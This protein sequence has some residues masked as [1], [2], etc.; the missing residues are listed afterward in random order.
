[1]AGN[2]VPLASKM[3]SQDGDEALERAIDGAMMMT[4]RSTPDSL[5]YSRPKFLGSWKSSWIVAH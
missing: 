5:E 3:L 4:G 1:M 2:H